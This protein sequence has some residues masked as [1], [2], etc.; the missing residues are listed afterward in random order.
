MSVVSNIVLILAS[1]VTKLTGSVD[2]VVWLL[3][4]VS[5]TNK[6][7]RKRICMAATYISVMCT[8]T[9]AAIAISY[10]GRQLVQLMLNNTESYWTAE[11]ILALPSGIVL[12]LYSIYL[13]YDWYQDRQDADDTDSNNI[14]PV[15]KQ[16]PSES[17]ISVPDQVMEKCDADTEM[18]VLTEQNHESQM[19]EVGLKEDEKI[20]N[21]SDKQ[22]TV[23]RLIIV[24]ILG[25]LDDFAVQCAL[26]LAETFSWYQLFLGVFIGSGIVVVFCVGIGYV[27]CIAKYIEKI[28]IWLIIGLLAV[29]TIISAFVIM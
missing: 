5:P 19:D 24:S 23:R 29:Y 25:S 9:A 10:L 17:A 8:V 13:F 21:Q 11:R 15:H 16:V 6:T 26:L 28:P 18:A 4:F 3:P 27:R 22:I 1:I 14:Q 12:F 7:K 20:G 2:D